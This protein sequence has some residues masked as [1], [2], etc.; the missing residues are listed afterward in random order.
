MDIFYKI[1]PFPSLPKRGI[2][3]KNPPPKKSLDRE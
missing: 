3:L 1:S 2:F